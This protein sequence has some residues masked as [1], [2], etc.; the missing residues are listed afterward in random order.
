MSR[1]SKIICDRCG[2]EIEVMPDEDFAHPMPW[3][4]AF[5]RKHTIFYQNHKR[6]PMSVER[7]LCN[8]CM[9]SFWKWWTSGRKDSEVNGKEG[10]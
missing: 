5:E 2:K 9:D 7:E 3:R 6:S 4:M 8:S 1:I 10:K